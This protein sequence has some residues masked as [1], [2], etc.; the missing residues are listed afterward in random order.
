MSSIATPST[1]EIAT[2][3]VAQIELAISQ[4]IPFLPKSFTHVLAKALAAVHVLLF[5]YSGWI[6]QQQFVR[7]ASIDETVIN[8][9]VVRPLVEWGRLVGVG[10]PLAAT[11][12]EHVI[13]VNVTNQV[14]DIPAGSQVLFPATGVLYLT[15]AAVA[16]SAATVQVSITAY[17]DQQG[18]GGEGSIGNLQPGDIVEFANPLPNIARKAT[19]LSQ[20]VT[21]ADAE[22]TETYRGRIFRRFQRRPQGGA[23]ADYQE[24]AEGVPGILAAYPYKGAPGE[25][26]VY[27]E[28]SVESSGSPDGIP[29]PAQLTA[30]AEAIDLDLEG[31]ASRRPVNAGVN[32][33][34]IARQTF[35]VL[36]TGLAAPDLTAAIDTIT[37]SVDDYLR[38]RE[39]YI[40]GL[41]VLPRLD[42][43]TLSA[44]SG[45]VDEAASS[46]GGSIATVALH[47]AGIPYTAYTLGDGEKAKLGTLST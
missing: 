31:L 46:T 11:R 1:Q 12:A 40:E 44:V 30:V 20:T 33:L 26:D 6:W 16:L 42:R 27:V 34:G 32:V 2:N 38:S 21:A 41:S 39:P 17:S 9:K 7:L 10:D 23:Y 19:V 22:Q 47:I 3:I 28:A 36:V 15:N 8:G 25:V 18:G 13:T 24:W 37:E 4:T 14:G 35:D 5:K 29:T 43:I 45:I